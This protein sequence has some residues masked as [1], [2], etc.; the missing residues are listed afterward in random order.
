MYTADLLTVFLMDKNETK[1][2]NGEY[3]AQ[4]QII[5]APKPAAPGKGL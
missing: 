3:L 1:S 5:A 2:Q 4:M